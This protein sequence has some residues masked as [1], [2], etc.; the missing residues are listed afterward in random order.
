MF[1]RNCG[2]PMA[3]NEDF[4]VYCGVTKGDGRK[5]CERCGSALTTSG[6]CNSC[7]HTTSSTTGQKSKVVAAL[8]G[9]LV[10]QLGVH[11]F[12][13][14]YTKKAWIQ[15]ILTIVTFGLGGFITGPWSTV[16]AI[17][18]LCNKIPAAD[19]SALVN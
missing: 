18:I 16:E 11:N 10:G 4:C 9:F 14:G 7:W 8:L 17:L 13:L 5:F 2:R 1:C 3:D 19:G 15:L 12:Y 6:Q